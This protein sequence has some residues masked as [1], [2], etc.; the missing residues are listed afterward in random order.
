MRLIRITVG[1]TLAVFFA[2]LAR[3]QLV[4]IRVENNYWNAFQTP[5]K[6]GLKIQGKDGKY[7]ADGKSVDSGAMLAF[8][9]AINEPPV[10]EISLE[11]L[12]LTQEWLNTNAQAAF[13][14]YFK[15]RTS[16]VSPPQR[17]LFER[18]FRELRFMRDVVQAYYSSFWTDDY[19][20]ISLTI[21]IDSRTILLSSNEQHQFMI[22]WTITENGKTSE[23]FNAHI[24]RTLAAILP[25][26]A[27]HKS[28]LDGKNLRYAL[29][30]HLYWELRDE[31]AV[32]TTEA[33]IPQDIQKIRM[34][35]KV[36][37]SDVGCIASIDVEGACPSW[38][39][40]LRS[41]EL[42]S[43]YTIGVSLPYEEGRLP[44]LSLF[45][46]KIPVYSQLAASVPWF[47]Q[48]LVRHP[49][50]QAEIRFVIDRSLSKRAS[51]KLLEDLRKHGKN[52]L[53][54]RIE[55]EALES[56]FL[57]VSDEKHNWS[58]WVIFP[59]GDMLLW[60]FKGDSVLDFPATK[61]M[62]WE[63]YNWKS[64]GALIRADGS[65]GQ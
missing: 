49:G 35:Y 23:S 38:N 10:R 42:P 11:N 12:G 9:K 1:L 32:L 3:A 14:E 63:Y 50:T 60:H 25:Q 29:S 8:I 55:K 22:P 62:S 15:D 36:E 6:G 40:T 13:K 59:N 30:E 18:N 34:K 54:G 5:V 31:W 65:E 48:Y 41:S 20:K 16:G 39:A 21:R 33:K 58:R 43:N 61:F 53:T 7:F 57:E 52:E 46:E 44:N 4:D 28:R 19:P 2:S 56:V 64:A 47:K 26:A 24:S 17:D 45:E 37:K 51:G 27:I